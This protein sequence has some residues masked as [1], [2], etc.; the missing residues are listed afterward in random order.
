MNILVKHTS[1]L[2]SFLWRGV[3]AGCLLLAACGE[4]DQT[5]AS[6][7]IASMQGSL[8]ANMHD[9][10]V[11][12][13]TLFLKA[14]GITS[15]AKDQ[16]TYQWSIAAP[17]SSYV[18]GQVI[19]YQFPR[20]ENAVTVT[21]SGIADGYYATSTTRAVTLIENS[22]TETVNGLAEGDGTFSDARDGQTYRYAHIGSYDWMTQNLNWA[23]AG[24]SYKN[25]PEYDII[26]GRLYSWDEATGAATCPPGWHAPD[27]A[28]WNDLGQALNDGVPV[29]FQSYWQKL[30][31]YATA[32]ADIHGNKLWTYDPNNTRENKNGWNALPAGEFSGGIFSDSGRYGHWWS[33][34]THPD[35]PD[36][37]YARYLIYNSAAFYFIDRHRQAYLSLRCVR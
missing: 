37:A 11:K 9:Y 27:T 36:Y 17:S 32:N 5:T 12:D 20:T 26:F 34:T 35:K 14:E 8:T 7:G 31:S 29:S 21:L 30:G 24:K 23:G 22:F 28:A 16:I 19:R 2:P 10:I 3:I 1:S 25:Q 18:W 15:P 33:A 6:T 13:T 4:D